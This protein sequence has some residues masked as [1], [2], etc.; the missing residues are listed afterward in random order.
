[1]FL[2]YA[3]TGVLDTRAPTGGEEDSDFE[4]LVASALEAHGHEV[5]R[6]VGTAGFLVDLAVV[7]P[8]RPGWYLLGIECDGATYHSSRSA[9]DRDRL[10]EAVLRDRGWRIHRVWSTDWFHRPGEQLRKIVAAIEKAR[11]QADEDEAEDEDGQ[12]EPPAEDAVSDS[13]GDI[14]RAEQADELNVNGEAGGAWVV[15]YVEAELD[16]PSTT[17]IHETSLPVL[18]SIVAGVVEIEGPIHRDELVR[19]VASL[20]GQQRTGPRIAQ[21]IAKAV[22]AGLRAGTLRADP[23]FVTHSRQAAVP[24]RRRSDV[25]SAALRRPEMIAP[26]ELRQAVERL[27]AEHLGIRRDEVPLLVA[28][29]LGFRTTSPKLKDT[30]EAI[31]A[32]M[33]EEHAI[34]LRD[35]KLFLA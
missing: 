19:R 20:W 30:I 33:L 24:V 5:H 21:A 2:R 18:A 8:A 32:R 14:E 12:E 3:A 1:M 10:R 35:G 15:P 31:V 6:Q 23:D 17:P 11:L 28:R 7:D 13:E 26:A 29:A 34:R 4:R 16:V 27:V 25:T 22:E 9:R